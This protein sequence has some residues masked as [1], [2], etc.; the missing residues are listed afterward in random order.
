M[1]NLLQLQNN[2]QYQFRDESLLR[3]AL[4]HCSYTHRTM[5]ETSHNQRL[6]FLGDAVLQLYSSTLLYTRFDHADES[7][8]SQAR[9]ALVCEQS[10][11]GYARTL[12]VGDC[13]LLGNGEIQTGGMQRDSILADAMEAIL[14][15]VYLDGGQ[16]PARLL[17]KRLLSPDC[18]RAIRPEKRLDAKTT[19]QLAF[20]GKGEV[21]Y[22]IVGQSGPDHA[23]RFEAQALLADKV[24]GYGEGTSKKHAER[25]AALDALARMEEG[26]AEE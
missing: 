11:A 15:A 23:K 2:L 24:I 19:L 12:H 22:R 3:L 6:E 20:A 13:L 7:A 18:E 17:I 25:N 21:S 10:L 5:D 1:D 16:E 26:K 8:L 14:G 9:A 4:T